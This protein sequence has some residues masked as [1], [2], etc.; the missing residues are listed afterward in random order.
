MK[1][2]YVVILSI[3]LLVTLTA[4]GAKGSPDNGQDGYEIPDFGN[5]IYLCDDGTNEGMA[6]SNRCVMKLSGGL[7][8]Y[9]MVGPDATDATGIVMCSDLSCKHVLSNEEEGIPITCEAEAPYRVGYAFWLEDYIYVVGSISG[10]ATGIGIARRGLDGGGWQD[11]A[12][13]EDYCLGGGAAVLG[14]QFVEDGKLYLS[15]SQQTTYQMAFGALGNECFGMLEIDCNSGK[16]REVVPIQKGV[17][18]NVYY[19]DKAENN[20]IYAYISAPFALLRD[21]TDATFDE[22]SEAFYGASETHIIMV[23]LDTLEIT[24]CGSYAPW[25]QERISAEEKSYFV[26][27]NSNGVVY[28]EKDTVYYRRLGESSSTKLFD[29][30]D[31]AYLESAELGEEILVTKYRHDAEKNH[32]GNI[33]YLVDKEGQWKQDEVSAEMTCQVCLNNGYSLCTFLEGE[34]KDAT[35]L[36]KDSDAIKGEGD[37][38]YRIIR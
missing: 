13:Y 2:R 15:V 12:Q 35:V 18:Q 3:L 20:L 33:Y 28:V 10:S 32:L 16:Y 11:I 25:P 19:I 38:Y 5:R 22:V 30:E 7:V 14:Y 36:I 21:L 26:G 31:Y 24:E 4:C 29:V 27:V 17:Y 34:M 23:N 1:N 8:N 9:Y 6:I 37:S